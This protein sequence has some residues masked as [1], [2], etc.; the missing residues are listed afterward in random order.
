MYF[1]IKEA[2]FQ[3]EHQIR[4]RFEDGSVGTVDLSD[5]LKEDT[6]FSQF[7]SE[8]YFKDFKIEYGTLVWGNGEVDIAPETLYER[9]TG[10]KIGFEDEK[11]L[12]NR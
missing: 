8:E 4:M 2:V 1:E 6:V 9:A 12:V 5:Y 7:S 11:K 3:K 10:K